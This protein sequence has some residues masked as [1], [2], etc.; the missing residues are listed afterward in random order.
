MPRNALY[1]ALSRAKLASGLFIV[2]NLKLTNK[3]SERDPVFRELKRLN[4][5]CSIIWPIR[6][7]SPTIY[8][9]NV[10]SLNLH[11]EDLISDSLIAQL[12]ILILQETMTTLI[13]TLDITWSFSSL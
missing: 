2:G 6:L 9:H 4:E 12:Q 10:R 13:D 1:T 7:T 5:L 11:S 3:I 8:F